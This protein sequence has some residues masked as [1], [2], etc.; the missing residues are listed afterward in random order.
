LP[1]DAQPQAERLQAT[2]TDDAEAVS[3]TLVLP[4]V[5]AGGNCC[6]SVATADKMAGPQGDADV[7]AGLAVSAAAEE[8]ET[9]LTLPV[10]GVHLL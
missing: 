7:E 5:T 9:P 3:R 8:R 2:G 4:H 1:L 6:K 10:N